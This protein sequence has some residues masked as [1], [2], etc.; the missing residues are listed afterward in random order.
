MLKKVNMT[1]LK[2]LPL[3]LL[4]RAERKDGNLN[5]AAVL[6]RAVSKG[7]N[8]QSKTSYYDNIR[9]IVGRCA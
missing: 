7:L 1:Y 9:K 2:A 6:V 8:A 5:L 3:H 4:R